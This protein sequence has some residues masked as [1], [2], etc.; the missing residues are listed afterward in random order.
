MIVYYSIHCF[1]IKKIMMDSQ[2]IH[3][4]TD[5]SSN[6]PSKKAQSA[7]LLGYQILIIRK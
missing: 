2:Q 3:Q 1:F 4:E 7:F 5:G 6:P